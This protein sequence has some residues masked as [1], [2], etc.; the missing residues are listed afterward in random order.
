LVTK[1]LLGLVLFVFFFY[2][3][4]NYVY[5]PNKKYQNQGGG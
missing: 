2:F 5:R 1:N 4:R 3:L